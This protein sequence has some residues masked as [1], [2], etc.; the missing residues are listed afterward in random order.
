MLA[1]YVDTPGVIIDAQTM[2]ETVHKIESAGH[3]GGVTRREGNRCCN[4]C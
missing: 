3:T 2:C 4:G 1:V